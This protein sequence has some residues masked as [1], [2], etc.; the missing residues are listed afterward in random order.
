[1]EDLTSAMVEAVREAVM[2]AF[3]ELRP[4][5]SQDVSRARRA[6]ARKMCDKRRG[7]GPSPFGERGLPSEVSG[8]IESDEH[9]G[10]VIGSTP[11]KA[12]SPTA[13]AQAA[14]RADLSDATFC[15]PQSISL[16][17]VDCASA[18][19]EASPGTSPLHRRRVSKKQRSVT[20]SSARTPTVHALEADLAHAVL[21]Q[22]GLG[23]Q[24]GSRS[25]VSV[26][27]V[28]MEVTATR[29]LSVV[30]PEPEARRSAAAS[31]APAVVRL[32]VPVAR[33]AP[34]LPAG[35]PQSKSD[36]VRDASEG[37]SGEAATEAQDGGA[38]TSS[39][40]T[41]QGSMEHLTSSQVLQVC[42]RE[43][44]RK[45]THSSTATHSLTDRNAE[46]CS[47]GRAAVRNAVPGV[48]VAS[49]VLPWD[50]ARRPWGSAAYQWSARAVVA[51]VVVAFFAHT[52]GL[53][54][55]R[56]TLP[57]CGSDASTCW[58]LE[59]MF[60]RLPL[61]A[62]SVLALASVGLKRQQ[63]QL[64]EAFVLLRAVSLE[65]GYVECHAR[66]VRWDMTAFVLI[67]LCTVV[68][69]VSCE[70]SAANSAFGSAY[71]GVSS[72]LMLS[73]FSAVILSLC[74]AMAH[75]CRSLSVMID[76]FCCDVVNK[77]RPREVA[78][79]WNLTQAVLRKASTSVETC[80]LALC[81]VMAFTVPMLLMDVSLW[82]ARIASNPS[83][84]AGLLIVCG[85]LYVLVVAATISE[86]CA[87]V[88][89]LV[90]AVS[91]GSGTDRARQR[92]VDYITSSAAGFYIFGLRL[93][94]GMVLKLMYVWCI[95]AF[96]VMPRVMP[97]GG[98]GIDL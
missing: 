67:W 15:S 63:A 53:S 38:S 88:P 85:I 7:L 39:E 34:Q 21:E 50:A 57:H 74:Y 17:D 91:F 59:A 36:A 80:V 96:Y 10:D 28:D 33:V 84:V 42:V 4:K 13:R 5:L 75:A 40:F 55:G 70:L 98:T 49:G 56:G 35:P 81:A 62:G 64:Q 41:L 43:L 65:R 44:A 25:T 86:K 71:F 31:T 2:A 87:R 51:A 3:Q 11:V 48:L 27:G 32:T 18:V 6:N 12:G 68:G 46:S 45:A 19:S 52:F 22:S 23:S 93:T 61:P 60:S 29:S 16:S 24:L 54:G 37:A 14:S 66:R 83:F 8:G 47:N 72:S 89:S 77:K 73:L 78:H 20:S 97:G 79:L 95:V 69:A 30:V 58:Q 26:P 76:E 1:M 90:N 9:E 82:G 94:M 92:T